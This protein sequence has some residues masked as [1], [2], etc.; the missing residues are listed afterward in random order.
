MLLQRPHRDNDP[1]TLFG[2]LSVFQQSLQSQHLGLGFLV[3]A[4]PLSR[5]EV[6]NPQSKP[7]FHNDV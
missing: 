2:R 5:N 3:V 4:K 7:G 6:I 1:A